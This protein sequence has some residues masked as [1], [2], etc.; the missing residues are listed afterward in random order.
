VSP[1][2]EAAL[3][4]TERRRWTTGT[5]ASARTRRTSSR[6]GARIG[7]RDRGQFGAH[8]EDPRRHGAVSQRRAVRVG[9]RHGQDGHGLLLHQRGGNIDAVLAVEV[10]VHQHDIG[11]RSSH[12]ADHQLAS[13]HLAD[14]LD[15]GLAPEGDAEREASGRR[16]VDDQHAD[17]AGGRHELLRITGSALR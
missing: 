4:W 15:S 12:L 16:V 2:S 14:D 5:R 1:N 6:R 13:R 17:A 3:G 11:P 10:D 8:L 9:G 7:R